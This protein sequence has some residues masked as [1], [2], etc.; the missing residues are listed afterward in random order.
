[1][2]LWDKINKLKDDVVGTVN[3]VVGGNAEQEELT[4]SIHDMFEPKLGIS[5]GTKPFA[6]KE[7]TFVYGNTEYSYSQVSQVKIVNMST[8]IVGGS[9]QVMLADGKLLNLVFEPYQKDR[10][11]KAMTYANEQISLLNGTSAK[12]VL[13]ANTG[14]KLEV[15]ES[16][17][18]LCYIPSGIKNVMSNAMRSGSVDTVMRFNEMTISLSTLSNEL[19]I[20]HK[21]NNYSLPLNAEY[22]DLAQEVIAYME[23]VKASNSDSMAIPEKV[24][25]QWKNET[26]ENKE[27]ALCGAKLEIPQSMD[28]FNSYRLKFRE[29]A[30]ECAD[31]AKQEYKKRVFNLQTYIDFFPEIYGF[32]FAAMVDKAMEVFVAEGVWSVTR[33]T[34][35]NEH[36]DQFHLAMDEFKVTLD[37]VTLTMQNNQQAVQSVMNFVP[38][39]QGGGFGLKGAAKGI[40]SATAFNLVRDAAESGL[41]NSVCTLNQA[42]QKELYDRINQDKLFE[43][44]FV[45]YWRVFI[46]LIY[47][48]RQNGKDIWWYTDEQT[49]QASNIF[50]NLSNPNFPQDQV[51]SVFIDILKTNPYNADYHKFM[52]MRF[53]ANEETEAI[54]N[55]FGFTD[56]ENPRMN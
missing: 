37:S 31:Y 18:Q 6:F 20:G 12:Y 34:F 49:K 42:Q 53:G 35:L 55:Y 23:E 13:P 32:Y 44:V 21:G 25:E 19:L 45:D 38:H 16:Y 14:S 7:N 22:L 17:A 50:A 39:V 10:F 27:F 24:Q 4:K 28:I 8:G 36:T 46:S 33:D 47:K 26:G 52:I 54:K 1:M 48:L 43:F 40:A 15:Y 3:T 41:A 11:I 9:V 29:L 56:F 30:C 51:L 2:A 5:I